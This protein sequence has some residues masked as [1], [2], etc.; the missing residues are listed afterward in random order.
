MVS[1]GL[2]LHAHVC[3]L[4]TQVHYF[5]LNIIYLK[6]PVLFMGTAHRRWPTGTIIKQF[7]LTNFGE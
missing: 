1:T 3:Y 4:Y 7:K 2:K 5:Y 6:P